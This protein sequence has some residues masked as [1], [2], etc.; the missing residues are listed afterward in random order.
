MFQLH[1]NKHSDLFA[2]PK[3]EGLAL[4]WHQKRLP[5]NEKV[6]LLCRHL[7][8]NKKRAESRIA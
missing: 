7:Q 6:T 3:D 8:I 2:S 1:N 4:R 5:T